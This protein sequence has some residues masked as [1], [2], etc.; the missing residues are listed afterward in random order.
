MI[1]HPCLRDALPI[2]FHQ[3]PAHIPWE[4][5]KHSQIIVI[6]IQRVLRNPEGRNSVRCV[7]ADV[8]RPFLKGPPTIQETPVGP[9]ILE[10]VDGAPIYTSITY[11]K[12]AA[13]IALSVGRRVGIDSVTMD[14]FEGWETIE[15]LYLQNTPSLHDADAPALALDLTPFRTFALRWAIFEAQLKCLSL[16]IAEHM[17]RLSPPVSAFVRGETAM[18][19]A[20][21][22]L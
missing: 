21:A 19:V 17:P 13:W 20:T 3:W 7:L 2:S 16:P 18:A 10:H 1:W 12:N 4:Q 5:P 22:H 6:E 8:L 11:S 9:A 14:P 15:D